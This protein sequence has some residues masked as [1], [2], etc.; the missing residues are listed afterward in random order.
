[1]SVLLHISDTHFG[2]EEAPVVSALQT[3][4]H[5]LK[6][7]ALILSGDITQRALSAQFE[8][9]RQFCE[10]LHVPQLLALPGNHDIPLYNVLLRVAAPY[11]K[12]AAA[13]GRD[14]EP[15]L[16]LADAVVIGV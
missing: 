3:L 13:F 8:A 2:T 14:L 15:V 7:D 6:P 12:Y 4:A 5:D 16:E 11:R 9:A 10:S 1:M